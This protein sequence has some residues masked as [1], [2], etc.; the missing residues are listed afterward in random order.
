MYFSFFSIKL[1]VK[2]CLLYDYRLRIND[3]HSLI[4]MLKKI[5]ENQKIAQLKEQHPNANAIVIILA[6]IMLWRGVWGLLDQYLF[7]DSPLLSSLVSIA[8]GAL[9]LYL[10][11][12]SL[13][14]LKR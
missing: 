4:S 2:L 3:R 12:F 8:L 14:N 9:I 5:K 1:L 6:I 10:D 11:D 13:D 7:P